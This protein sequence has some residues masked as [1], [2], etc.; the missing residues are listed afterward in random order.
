MG[1]MRKKLERRRQR[2]SPRNTARLCSAGATFLFLLSTGATGCHA[3]DPCAETGVACGGSPV[4]R[5][6]LSDACQDPTIRTTLPRTY[7]GQPIETA[8]QAPP[9][10]TT[11]DWCADLKYTASGIEA[12]NLPHDTS[13]IIGAYIVY[14][15]D[16]TYSAFVTTS[17]HTSIEFSF[18]CLSRF[19]T[20]TGC[21]DFG[22]AFATYGAGLGGVKETDCSDSA[23]GCLCSYTVEN[24]SAGSNLN[25]TWSANG[26]VLTH[27]A[28]SMVLPSQV[29][30][31]TN[32][33]HMT[34]WGHDG[35]GIMDL[36]G[37]RIMDLGRIVCGNG[38]VER[39]EECDPPNT[40]TC[41]SNCRIIK[42]P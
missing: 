25:G 28:G 33:D 32:G 39:G 13:R 5:W 23:N 16:H 38:V 2:P 31:C 7:L 14:G 34:L 27:F 35:T 37:V 30:F 40:Q 10:P 8:G 42:G 17:A 41:D 22:V 15:D 9:E 11:S 21:A 3:N 24:D 26:N 1:A 4:G 12:L 6:T 19:G 18:D 20:F 36:G 29:D